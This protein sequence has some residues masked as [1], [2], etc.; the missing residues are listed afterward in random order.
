MKTLLPAALAVLIT[1]SGCGTIASIA[2]GA[3]A[4]PLNEVPRYDGPRQVIYRIDEHRYITTEAYQYCDRYGHV[5]WHDDRKNLHVRLSPWT[6]LWQ[7]RYVV[8]P[9]E[10]RIAI[11]TFSCEDKGC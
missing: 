1:L 7:G 9:G 2:T 11:P 4:M 3:G 6:A 10:E 5:Y 8:E